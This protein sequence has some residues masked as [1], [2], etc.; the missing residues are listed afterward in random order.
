VLLNKVPGEVKKVGA[1]GA[2]DKKKVYRKLEK[3]KIQLVIPP[4]RLQ[5]LPSTA[6]KLTANCPETKPFGR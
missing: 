2:Y 5:G 3:R 4:P 6:I 1:D